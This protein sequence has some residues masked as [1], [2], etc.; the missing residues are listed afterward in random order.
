M[1]TARTFSRSLAC[2]CRD[3]DL[4]YLLVV[5]S[6]RPVLEEEEGKHNETVRHYI[7]YRVLIADCE[8]SWN[9]KPKFDTFAT[10]TKMMKDCSY[11]H[12]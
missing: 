2:L 12:I 6:F 1:Y 8:F 4:I 3:R 10:V 11:L 7:N 9:L 5:T